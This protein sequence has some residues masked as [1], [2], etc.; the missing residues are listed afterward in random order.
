MN[1]NILT[2]YKTKEDIEKI[3]TWT[4]VDSVIEDVKKW[5]EEIQK[6]KVNISP[7]FDIDNLELS[8][9]VFAS[10]HDTFI[11]KDRL[12][13]MSNSKIYE[14]YVKIVRVFWTDA[15]KDLSQD[16]Y[17]SDYNR[18]KITGKWTENNKIFFD[19]FRDKNMWDYLDELNNKF[20]IKPLLNKKCNL[21]DFEKYFWGN[22]KLLEVLEI[23]KK[24][25]Q[26]SRNKEKWSQ[27]L[28]KK[29]ELEKSMRWEIITAIFYNEFGFRVWSLTQEDKKELLNYFKEA[30]DAKLI[31]KTKKSFF[32]II[33]NFLLKKEEKLDNF[34]NLTHK[35]KFLIE[36]YWSEYFKKLKKDFGEKKLNNFWNW[37]FVYIFPKENL[38]KWIY[39]ILWH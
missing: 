10:I 28:L 7:D 3:N 26:E 23:I 34:V 27:I 17:N 9:Q 15:A 29:E 20:P 35:E 11:L 36:K 30:E 32:K 33:F 2:W 31:K 22:D 25:Y 38:I 21:E 12:K 4:C 13:H 16:F 5:T 1:N 8:E 37:E 6:I 39:H 24:I 18:E 14:E 19:W